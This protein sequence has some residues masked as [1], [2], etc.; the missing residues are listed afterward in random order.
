MSPQDVSLA[1]CP[2]RIE[3]LYNA[4]GGRDAAIIF[5]L[6]HESGR[7]NAVGALMTLQLQLVG[8]WELP[9]IPVESVATVPATLVTLKCQLVSPVANPRLPNPASHLLPHC[10]D[11]G[12][13][14]EHTVNVLT[15]T[16]SGFRD[17]LGKLSSEDAVFRSEIAALL[18]QDA[19]RLQNFFT[20][21]Y[22]VD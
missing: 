17:L 18:D 14:T 9:I 2:S 11:R 4:D 21:E 7:E 22:L 6:Q 1:R 12:S 20:T 13:L 5:L 16:T 3:R 8:N 19:N 10:S 15:D